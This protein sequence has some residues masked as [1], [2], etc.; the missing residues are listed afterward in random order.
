MQAYF[1]LPCKGYPCIIQMLISYILFHSRQ[2][3]IALRSR[4]SC[5]TR[6]NNTYHL[7]PALSINTDHQVAGKK[8]AQGGNFHQG[9]ESKKEKKREQEGEGEGEGE[10][11]RALQIDQEEQRVENNII[12]KKNLK[13]NELEYAS[14]MGS[15]LNDSQI[16]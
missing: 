2:G 10:R 16:N 7:F 6:L 1:C 15:W 11:F 14:I 12:R 3:T 8:E 5:L 4:V 13:P 9:K